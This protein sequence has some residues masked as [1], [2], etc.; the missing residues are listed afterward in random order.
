MRAIISDAG[1][2]VAADGAR[3][4]FGGIGGAHG[5]AP[6]E[7]RAFGLESQ[8]DDFAGTHELG[9][10]AE[11]AA[12]AMDGVKSFRFLARQVQGF[13]GDNLKS[14]FVN[15]RHDLA[16]QSASEGVGLDDC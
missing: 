6:L 5:V 10:F 16:G 12:F 13:D 14:G 1:A 4:G 3:S 8:H 7:N 11:E 9:Q 15:S 2:E